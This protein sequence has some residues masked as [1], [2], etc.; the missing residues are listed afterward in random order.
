M[1]FIKLRYVTRFR[2]TSDLIIPLE[3]LVK[4]SIFVHTCLIQIG[5]TYT[6]KISKLNMGGRPLRCQLRLKH[7]SFYGLDVLDNV[8]N[9][10]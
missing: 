6:V 10:S 8:L 3:F 9:I 4:S 1:C 7:S 5:E 2:H